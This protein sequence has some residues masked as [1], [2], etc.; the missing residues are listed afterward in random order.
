[1]S[2][3]ELF[4]GYSGKHF[5]LFQLK[6]LVSGQHAKNEFE[7]CSGILPLKINTSSLMA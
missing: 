5:S 4:T 7:P 1:M 3:T 6:N 2:S